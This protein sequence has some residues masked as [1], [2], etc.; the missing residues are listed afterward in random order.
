MST[1][2]ETPDADGSVGTAGVPARA[3]AAPGRCPACPHQ[4][5]R[6]D[7]IGRR[8]CTASMAASRDNGC[9]CVG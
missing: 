3:E 1:G 6:H 5:A 4:W 7:A 2:Y 9:V 8:Y